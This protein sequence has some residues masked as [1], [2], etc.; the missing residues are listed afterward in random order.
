[1]TY[2]CYITFDAS[3]NAIAAAHL[4][5]HKVETFLAANAPNGIHLEVDKALYD[6]IS[7]DLQAWRLVE[8]VP[9]EVQQSLF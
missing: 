9:T 4:L 5:E 7:R 1:M 8:G 6:Q 2:R 3:G